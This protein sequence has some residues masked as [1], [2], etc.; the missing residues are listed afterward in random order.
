MRK[1]FI[2]STQAGGQVPVINSVA[3]TWGEL[4]QEIK[5]QTSLNPDGMQAINA[6]SR[7]EFLDASST[8]PDT[9]FTLS[10]QPVKVKAGNVDYDA[11]YDYEEVDGLSYNQLKSELKA[12]RVMATEE[13][14]EDTVDK[15]GN[16]TQLS[17]VD[18]KKRLKEVY[19]H[20]GNGPVAEEAV[21]SNGTPVENDNAAWKTLE[22]RI[23]TIEFRLGI[24]NSHNAPAYIDKA[25]K[26]LDALNEILA[27]R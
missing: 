8:L 22:E 7:V 21:P 18:L 4:V 13:E 11:E 17:V 23:L 1:V 15:V 6:S 24:Y 14:D 16:Y 10:I 3:T 26:E 12:I 19:E 25:L 5:A 9:D 2:V 27:R 20:I